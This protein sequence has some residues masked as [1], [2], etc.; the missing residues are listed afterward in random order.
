MAATW[1]GVFVRHKRNGITLSDTSTLL[2]ILF[3]TAFI[4]HS[5]YVMYWRGLWCNA[6][7]LLV[8]IVTF[9]SFRRCLVAYKYTM[10][11]MFQARPTPLETINT[12]GPMLP[13]YIKY[14]KHTG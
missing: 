2:R 4:V 6:S 3:P 9:G 13:D 8:D 10:P 12:T 5:Y 14:G 1:H 11:A 7:G